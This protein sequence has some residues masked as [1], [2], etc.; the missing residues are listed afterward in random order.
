MENAKP[1]LSEMG[2]LQVFLRSEDE[3]RKGR[4]NGD[5]EEEWRVRQGKDSKTVQSE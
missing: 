3:E 4:V 1:N 5:W 2:K